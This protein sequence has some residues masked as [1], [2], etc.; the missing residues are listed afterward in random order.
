MDRA[1]PRPLTPTIAAPAMLS[2]AAVIALYGDT[3]AHWS[4]LARPMFAVIVCAVLIGVVARFSIRGPG[5]TAVA[6]ASIALLIGGLPSALE[7]PFRSE[8]SSRGHSSIAGEWI[9][10]C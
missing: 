3:A 6:T 2:A 9:L 10:R 7:P 1:R 4:V 8:T 5:A